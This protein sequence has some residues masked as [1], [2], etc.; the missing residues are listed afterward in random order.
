MCGSA[1]S[2]LT[3]LQ[4]L[5]SMGFSR[6]EYWSLSFPPPGDLPNP[7]IKFLS[8]SLQ[9]DSL[10][11]EL[12]GESQL[13][14][15]LFL[16]I[17]YLSSLSVCLATQSCPT[18]CNPLNCSPQGSSGSWG[19]SRQE[20]WSVLPWPLPGDLPKSRIKRTSPKLQANSLP[21]EPSAKPK[22]TGVSVL[23]L[24]PLFH[25]SSVHSWELPNPWIK[26]GFPAMPVDSFT[27]WA[28]REDPKFSYENM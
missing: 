24:H 6:Q 13:L 8:L 23:S 20:Y 25:P 2:Y 7:G 5:L 9:A 12:S 21:S 22:N 17:N 15:S 27:R 4:V 11:L 18:L 19:F 10:P 3:V 16:K 14:N 26:L 28:T 1:Q